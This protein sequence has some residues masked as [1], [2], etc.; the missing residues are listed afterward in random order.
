ML[1]EILH[2]KDVRSAQQEVRQLRTAIDEAHSSLRELLANFR[3]RMDDR[4]LVHAISDVLDQLH[5]ETGIH[6]FFQNECGGKDTGLSPAQEIQIFR[7]VQEALSNVRKHSNACNVRVLMSRRKNSECS[8][9]IEDDGLGIDAAPSRDRPGEHV[10]LS[11][12]RDR[13]ARIHGQLLIE[14][15][16]GEG[17]RVDLTFPTTLPKQNPLE[18][19]GLASTAHR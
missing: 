12:M 4:G 5:E 7:I 10:G 9:L 2:R 11:I 17:T 8:I 1:G 3:S 13:A 6:T 18:D 16:P 15:E 19:P 14:S